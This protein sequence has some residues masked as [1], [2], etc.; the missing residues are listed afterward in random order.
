MDNKGCFYIDNLKIEKN[1]WQHS[2]AYCLSKAVVDNDLKDMNALKQMVKNSNLFNDLKLNLYNDGTVNI[3]MFD[4]EKDPI[5]YYVQP[6]NLFA[7]KRMRAI[8]NE[9]D[10]SIKKECPHEEYRNVPFK[11]YDDRVIMKKVELIANE[12]F[13]N[14]Y[15]KFDE[16]NGK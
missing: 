3:N 12:P 16:G 4:I 10:L 5:K 7:R 11:M 14:I 6:I 2:K 15:E 8:S 13:K 1:S 9:I